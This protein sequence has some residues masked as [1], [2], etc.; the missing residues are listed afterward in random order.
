MKKWQRN[1]YHVGFG[2]LF[3]IGYYF[4]H[5]PGATLFISFLLILSVIFDVQRFRKPGF[6]QWVFE[7]LSSLVKSKERFQ[8]T[9]TTYFLMGV[10]LSIILF[11]H[12]I[13]V[14]SLTFLVLGD[15][16]AATVGERYG[17]V[18]I[19]GKTL[20][21]SLTFFATALASGTKLYF[22]KI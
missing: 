19:L 5:R 8:P 9:G 21:G 17:R 12:H 10:L 20:E 22:F 15:V 4:G 2:I 16:T 7:H 14:A 18:K 1:L 11:P 6:N 3:P 13:T